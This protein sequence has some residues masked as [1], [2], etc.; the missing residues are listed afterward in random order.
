MRYMMM[1]MMTQLF[2]WFN[3]LIFPRTCFPLRPAGFFFVAGAWSRD[4]RL[5]VSLGR[6]ESTPIALVT[7][8]AA[9]SDDDVIHRPEVD[10]SMSGLDADRRSH[11][12]V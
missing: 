1:M 10:L 3:A 12:L 8:S 4:R 7:G 11:S 6:C 5:Q 2:E 9:T